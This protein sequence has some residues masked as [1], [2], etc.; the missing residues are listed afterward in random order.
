MTRQRA[1]LLSIFRSE[2][3]Y[4]QHKTA[5]E[6]LELARRR[7]PEISRATVYNNLRSMESEGFIRRITSETG[8]DVYDS[9]FK[10]HGH[11]ICTECH[12]IKD[13]EAPGLLDELSILAGVALDAY[14]LK[15]RYVCPLC[16]SGSKTKIDI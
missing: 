8:A 4:S 7:M 1:L 6:I 11:L 15:L 13:V 12:T 3:C 2:A 5:D 14:E 16:R 10:L 9:S